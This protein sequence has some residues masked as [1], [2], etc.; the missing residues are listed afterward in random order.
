MPAIRKTT[1]ARTALNVNRKP[2][3]TVSMVATKQEAMKST[4]KNT[5]RQ[6]PL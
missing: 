2:A 4:W 1:V 3:D 5:M 6:L